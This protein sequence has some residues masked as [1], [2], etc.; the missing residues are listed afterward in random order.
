MALPEGKV[1]H[2][3]EKVVEGWRA[4][5]SFP[6]VLD[7]GQDLIINQFRVLL[8]RGLIR[9]EELQLMVNDEHVPV[10]KN[11]RLA[12]WPTGFCDLMD[13]QLMELIDWNKENKADTKPETT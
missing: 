5:G 12:T 4:T 3:V 10:N 2:W 8:H 13:R 11:G 7:V 1:V 9:P 6:L